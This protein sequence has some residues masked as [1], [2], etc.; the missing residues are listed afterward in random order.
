MTTLFDPITIGALALP[1]RIVMAPLTHARAIG[2][3][4]VPS[5]LMAEYY[6]QRASAGL[7]LSEATSSAC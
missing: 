5:A 2:P 4:R 1:N 3:D 7:L 6:V